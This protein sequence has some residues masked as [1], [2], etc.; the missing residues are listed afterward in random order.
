M[1]HIFVFSQHFSGQYLWPENSQLV[2]M[3]NLLVFVNDDNVWLEVGHT[4]VGR[5]GP[6]T[7]GFTTLNFGSTMFAI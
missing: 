4:E 2:N 1:E 3:Q 7:C 5:N 6:S